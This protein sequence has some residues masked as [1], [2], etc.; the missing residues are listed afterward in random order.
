MVIGERAGGI[1]GT[2]E[3][4]KQKGHGERALKNA[5]DATLSRASFVIYNPR[6]R[7]ALAS[8]FVPGEIR[9]RR[10]C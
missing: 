8:H 3:A 2:E 9:R 5:N 7:V 6:T 4:E 1:G 10:F